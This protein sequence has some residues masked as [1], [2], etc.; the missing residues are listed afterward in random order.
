MKTIPYWSSLQRYHTLLI[1][2]D[3]DFNIVPN[4]SVKVNYLPVVASVSC[5]GFLV[6]FLGV[7]WVLVY[8]DTR[9]ID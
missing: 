5:S 4:I 8:N 3:L 1:S 7:A 2:P 6:A 9:D